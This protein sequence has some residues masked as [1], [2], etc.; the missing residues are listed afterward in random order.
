MHPTVILTRP[1]IQS[2]RFV[3]AM[4][5]ARGEALTYLI[6]P[7]M[8]IVPVDC[9][10]VAKECAHVIFTSVNGVDQAARLGVPKTA[11]AW[12]VG[13]QTT[14]AARALGFD[15]RN[16]RGSSADLI[17]M[18]R[19][20]A[21]TGLM[22]H[23]RGAHASG[24]VVETLSAAGCEIAGLVTYQQQELSPPDQLMAAF[25]TN[26]SFIV[27]L[28]SPRSARIFSATALSAAPLHLVAI[29]EATLQE[30][31]KRPDDKVLLASTPD[32]A[33]M[34]SAIMTV[35]DSLSP[36]NTP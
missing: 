19:D 9:D 12:C 25:Q 32:Q 7:L 16:A 8:E 15:T 28:F 3:A 26:D 13:D 20:A 36:T 18:I 14:Q 6:A 35:I 21:P 22:V 24:R 27:P 30:I 34:I 2:E 29:S 33:G 31:P 10:P 5:A 11:I 17:A 4:D 1:K 23:L